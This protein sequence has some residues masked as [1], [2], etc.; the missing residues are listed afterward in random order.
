MR[1]IH[2]RE[3]RSAYANV[4]CIGKSRKWETNRDTSGNCDYHTIICIYLNIGRKATAMCL[5]FGNIKYILEFMKSWFK[6]DS[7]NE[8]FF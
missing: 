6:K 2:G 8:S 7:K 4:I 1:L 3:R 5:T